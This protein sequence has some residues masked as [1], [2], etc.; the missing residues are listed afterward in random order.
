MK[1]L[2]NLR[3]A[4]LA[5]LALLGAAIAPTA[6][7]QTAAP[8]RPAALPARPVPALW[9]VADED[10]TIYLFGT[11]HALPGG[12]DWL[13]GPV[14]SALAQSGE[15][16]TE[17]PDPDPAEQAAALRR[18][19]LLEGETLRSLM[20]E[21]DRAAFEALLTRLKLR[22]DAFDRFEPWLAGMSIGMMPYAMAGYGPDDGAESVLRKAALAQGKTL[23][24]LET[25]DYQLSLFDTLPRDKQLVLLRDAVR[26]FD[27]SV[28][29]ID[30]MMRE[31]AQGDPEGLAHLVN[32]AMDDPQVVDV[33][34]YQRNHAWAAWVRQRLA[35]P[36]AVF[37]AVGAGHLA[38]PDSVQAALKAQGIAA[39]RVQ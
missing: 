20:T 10:T 12:L 34:L 3:H 1:P 28:A 17:I 30:Q 15:L 11:V 2:M 7:A 5:A 23:G 35:R 36:G 4:C 29:V 24:A 9:K 8:A 33:L 19:G 38:G 6:S 31:W 14:A 37:V 18:V 21:E 39:V 26:E 22:P 16:V 13:N 27:G 32:D 25:L